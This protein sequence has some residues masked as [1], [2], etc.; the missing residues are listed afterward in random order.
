MYE[1][2]K[3]NP[4]DT[5]ESIAE[6]YGV[7]PEVLVKI[8]GLNNSIIGLEYLVVPKN[9]TPFQ[10]YKV[11]KGDSVYQIAKTYKVD[12]DLLLKLN[13]LDKNDYIYPNQTLI[14]PRSNYQIYLTRNGDTLSN[15]SDQYNTDITY[16]LEE[17]RN[18]SLSP[19]QIVIIKEKWFSFFSFID[20]TPS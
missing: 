6:L 5:I 14:I 13:G 7:D 17:N 9:K 8:N 20:I 2:Y 3:I 18:L 15:I 4:N 11:K 1:V 10:Y 16:I 19:D 12:E